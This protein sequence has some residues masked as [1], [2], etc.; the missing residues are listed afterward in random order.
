MRAIS[1]CKLTQLRSASSYGYCCKVYSS[2]LPC[3]VGP[4]SLAPLI[5]SSPLLKR[6]SGNFDTLGQRNLHLSNPISPRNDRLLFL[7]N[8]IA[9]LSIR[10]IS[11]IDDDQ[12]PR[13]FIPKRVKYQLPR[14]IYGSKNWRRIKRHQ[15]KKHQKTKWRKKFAAFIR[16][17]SLRRNIRKEKAFRAEILGKVREAEEFDPEKYVKDIF[18]TIDSAP[19]IETRSDADLIKVFKLIRK[20]RSDTHLVSDIF[21]D[22]VPRKYSD[23]FKA[24]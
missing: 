1:L 5:N 16:Q 19:K 24:Q 22:P 6:N 20:Y 8:K 21:D 9:R 18:T 12:P 13:M 15:M 11:N 23:V 2:S 7:T 17:L 10:T 14:I 4:R 3:S